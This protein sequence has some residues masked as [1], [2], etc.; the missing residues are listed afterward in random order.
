MNNIAAEIIRKLTLKF[1][2]KL[3][4]RIFMRGE[5][6]KC[7]CEKIF[8]E[9]LGSLPFSGYFLE[10]QIEIFPLLCHVKNG[11]LALPILHM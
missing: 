2:N 8:L 9:H 6:T 1:A 7:T 5:Q 11:S 10:L 4:R 3:L